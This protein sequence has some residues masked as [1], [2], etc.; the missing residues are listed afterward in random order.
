MKI[1]LTGVAGG[2]GSSAVGIAADVPGTSEVP[3]TWRLSSSGAA[4]DAA[5]PSEDSPLKTATAITTGRR[6]R[7]NQLKGDLFVIADL[8]IGDIITR[9]AT[10]VNRKSEW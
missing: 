4:V 10:Q 8:H 1:S 3:G 6:A 5:R 9:A 7:N 2:E